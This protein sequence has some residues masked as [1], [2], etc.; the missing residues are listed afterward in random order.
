MVPSDHAGLDE[1]FRPT[2]D[3]E[4][5]AERAAALLG[6]GEFPR[7][8]GNIAP[9]Q[10]SQE[11]QVYVRDP[12]VKACVLEFAAGT[13]EF[14][15]EEGPFIRDDGRL[16]LEVHHVVPLSSGGPNTV[17]NAVAL[18]P[19]CHRRM[20]FGESRGADLAQLCARVHR[21]KSQPREPK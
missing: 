14:C 2:A 19:N 13:C 5:L 12:T 15:G 16:Y 8:K 4:L 21:I 11:G 10:V 7:P 9:P 20:H 1:L 6:L 3:R 17:D 18:C